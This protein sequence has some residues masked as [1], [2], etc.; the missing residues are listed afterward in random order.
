[1]T[2]GQNNKTKRQTK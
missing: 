2:N 1:M